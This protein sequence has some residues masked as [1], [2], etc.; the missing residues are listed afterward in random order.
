MV[1][2]FVFHLKILSFRELERLKKTQCFF[3]IYV[4][5][6]RIFYS[7]K[8]FNSNLKLLVELWLS[9][10]WKKIHLQ[11]KSK[12][13]IWF[14]GKMT[15]EVSVNWNIVIRSMTNWNELFDSIFCWRGWDTSW[16]F[17]FDAAVI[18]AAQYFEETVISPIGI[19][20]VANQPVWCVI[21]NAPTQNTNCVS[22]KLFS[23]NVLINACD[24]QIAQ[25]IKHSSNEHILK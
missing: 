25:M 13:N 2:N 17:S 10:T 19:P 3:I 22:A 1:V 9:L 4:E 12:Y 16:N 24:S 15:Q 6:F 11:K 21:L 8:W 14:E 5:I 7:N 20:A 18:G 23:M